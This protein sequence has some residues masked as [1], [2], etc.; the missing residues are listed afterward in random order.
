LTKA[1]TTSSTN[2]GWNRAWAHASG[3][4]GAIC[5]NWAN[6]FRKWSSGPNTTDGRKI[7][8]SSPLSRTIRPPSPLLR[9]YIDGPCGSAPS[10]L[11][12]QPANASA[13]AGLD[14]LARQIDMRGGELRPIRVATLAMQDADQIDDDTVDA[15]RADGVVEHCGVGQAKFDH[16]DARQQQQVLGVLD[17]ARADDDAFGRD[18]TI[19]I[20]GRIGGARGGG[21][22]GKAGNQVAADET[23]APDDKNIAGLHGGLR[24]EHVTQASMRASVATGP[25]APSECESASS[26]SGE[27]GRRDR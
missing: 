11:M 27:A 6:R 2:T 9:R 24:D 8:Q 12:K 17:I 5:C 10:A 15:K 14:D 19:G 22:A 7:V 21:C 3:T 16:F 23:G 25:T 18:G 1:C 13:L 4:T 20:G 26:G